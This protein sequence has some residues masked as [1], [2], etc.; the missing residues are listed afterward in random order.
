MENTATNYS[1]GNELHLEGAINQ[2]FANGFTLGLGGYWYQQISDD[3]GT[4]NRIGPFKGRVL[5]LGP[6]IGYTIKAGEIPISLSGRWF[7][8]FDT[9]NRVSGDS[10]FATLSMPLFVYPAAKPAPK[11]GLITK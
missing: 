10:V 6:L 9:E 3:G 1:T 8:E 4:G 7:H 11:P 2:H 5:A